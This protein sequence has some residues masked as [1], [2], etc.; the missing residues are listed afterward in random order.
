MSDA[1]STS[2]RRPPTI[3]LTAK[4][5]ETA[6]PDSQ[7]EADAEQAASAPDAAPAHAG[8]SSSRTAPYA[9]GVVIGAVGVAADGG[10]GSNPALDV[11]L[12][13]SSVTYA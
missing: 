7:P 9:I 2:R 3:D 1:D 13:L 12:T 8:S 4:E 6:G 11:T 5:V 10:V